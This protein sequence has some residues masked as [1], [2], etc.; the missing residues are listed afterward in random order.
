MVMRV[1]VP[2]DFVAGDADE[3]YGSIADVFRRVTFENSR[4]GDFQPIGIFRFSN[5]RP[6][7]LKIEIA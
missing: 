3:G 6:R 4:A 1:K 2:P 7:N 5:I